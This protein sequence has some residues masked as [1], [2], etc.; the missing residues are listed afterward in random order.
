MLYLVYI[1]NKGFISTF[2]K[3][4]NSF[5][6]TLDFNEVDYSSTEK[7]AIDIAEFFNGIVMSIKG[8]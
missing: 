3:M 2:D 1:D 6:T 4:S 5:T 8:N 7:V